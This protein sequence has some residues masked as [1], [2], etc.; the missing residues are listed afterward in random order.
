MEQSIVTCLLKVKILEPEETTVAR[1]Q[2]VNMFLQQCIHEHNYRGT[3]GGCIFY[4][5]CAGWNT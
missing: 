2:L 5:V 4:A 1:K 3:V